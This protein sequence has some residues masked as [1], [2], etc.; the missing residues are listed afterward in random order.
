MKKN[1]FIEALVKRLIQ[2]R[3]AF[4]TLIAVATVFS[5]WAISGGL[6]ID[7]SLAIWFLEDDETYLEYQQFQR[8]Y[9]SDEIVIA[10][11]PISYQQLPKQINVLDALSIDLERLSGVQSVFSIAQARYPIPMGGG[12]RWAPFYD[13]MR[14]DTQQQRLFN[15]LVDYRAQLVSEDLEYAFLYTQLSSSDQIEAERSALIAA[16]EQ[17]IKRYYEEAH[18]TGPPILNQEYNKALQKEA[19][20]FGI[21]TLLVI[22]LMLIFLLPNR[23]LAFI[24]ALAVVLPTLFLFGLIASFG[25]KLNMISALIP[26][27]LLV[28]A[29]SDV[30]HILNAFNQELAGV[31]N[32]S[33]VSIVLTRAIQ[34]SVIPC[35]LTTVTTIVGYFALYFSALPALKSMGLWASLGIVIAFVLA[36]LVIVL[37]VSFWS[38]ET[39]KSQNNKISSSL[40]S[41]RLSEWIISVV[42]HRAKLVL[43]SS[44]MLLA[45]ATILAL[46]VKVTTD[47]LALLPESSAKEALYKVEELLGSSS[48]LQLNLTLQDS[49]TISYQEFLE[50]LSD[51]HLQLSTYPELGNVF[52]IH[53]VRSFLEKGYTTA[54]F[55]QMASEK[56]LK[57]ALKNASP[58]DN[59]V[60]NLISPDLNTFVITVGFSQMPTHE[61]SSLFAKI[62][63]DFNAQ[64][65]EE[66]ALEIDGFATVFATL[67]A[68]VVSSQ[69]TTFGLAFL[70]ILLLLTWY[71]KNFRRAL[72]VLLPNLM[73]L[74]GLFALMYV[75]DISLGVTTAMITPIILGIA[76]DDTL[77]LLYHFLRPHASMSTQ[78]LQPRLEGAIRYATP[79]LLTSTISLIAGFFIIALSNTPAVSEFGLLCLVAIAIALLADLTFLPALIRRYW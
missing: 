1:Y 19:G 38:V 11:L 18:I 15:E 6:Q 67:N 26:T 74:F 8:D 44:V 78:P 54:S 61:L 32:A 37:G 79:A 68:F 35:A 20:V 50:D 76:M 73:P 51:F 4:I 31:P 56:T 57:N 23:R 22:A 41:S 58:S 60:F 45:L 5:V 34:R 2:F 40:R 12:L 59:N 33:S 42:K 29:L 17:T 55:A 64:F 13:P 16:I 9:G 72:I 46:K 70:V 66:I 65:G 52:S 21:L 47:S 3:Y 49:A 24:A 7:N 69:L 10:A 30:V 14:Q 43:V 25:V 71:L 36:Y 75:F 28:Y 53:S 27:L 39:L 48:R 77:H 63:R 62:E